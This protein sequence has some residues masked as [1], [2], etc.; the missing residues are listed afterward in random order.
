MKMNKRMN[1]AY[2]DL[3][4]IED[5]IEESI[6][7]YD[8]DSVTLYNIYTSFLDDMKIISNVYTN[9]KYNLDGKIKVSNLAYLII[10]HNEYEMELT[11]KEWNEIDS[12]IAYYKNN[13]PNTFQKDMIDK[14]LNKYYRKVK[15]GYIPK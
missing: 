5:K 13:Q 15:N 3:L 10:E 1:K 4:K 14:N 12:T 8:R 2:N 7:E 6:K 11:S 9:D